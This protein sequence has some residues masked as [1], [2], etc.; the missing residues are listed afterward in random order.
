MMIH[1]DSALYHAK[2]LGRD[3]VASFTQADLAASA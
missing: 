3:R 1:A 2:H